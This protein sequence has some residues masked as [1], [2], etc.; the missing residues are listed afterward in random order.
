MFV[1]FQRSRPFK[2]HWE[3]YKLKS[4]MH[5]NGNSTKTG[6]NKSS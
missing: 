2:C 6:K 4:K 1:F 5:L 3:F